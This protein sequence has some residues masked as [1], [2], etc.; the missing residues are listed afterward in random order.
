MLIAAA[1]ALCV[2]SL[3]GPARAENDEAASKR[4]M[5]HEDLWLMRRL[6]TPVASPDGRRAVVAVTEPSYEADDTVA[7]LWLID[8]AGD[9]P[10]RR[11]T[12]T[13]GPES[14][15]AWSPD[16]SRLA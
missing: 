16:G 14:D 7:D 5:T 15:P 1:A 2:L 13:P 12:S 11:L 8:L 6:G 10:P 9:T 4:P 3:P